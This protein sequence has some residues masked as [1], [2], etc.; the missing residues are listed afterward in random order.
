MVAVF[1]DN[2][3]ALLHDKAVDGQAAADVVCPGATLD[4]KVHARFV[5]RTES[6]FGRTP[7]MEAD[8]VQSVCAADVHDAQP[9]GLVGGRIPRFR[10]NAAFL[11]AAEK[12][13]PA[14]DRNLRAVRAQPAQA[15]V[16]TA[17]IGAAARVQFGRKLIKV[18]L[19]LVPRPVTASRRGKN[20]STDRIF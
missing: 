19:E 2:A 20:K 5:G 10:E 15:E 4:I 6:G 9:F 14:V 16:L 12:Y 8:V 18:G 3:T 7:G 17:D 13:R 1:A 11:C